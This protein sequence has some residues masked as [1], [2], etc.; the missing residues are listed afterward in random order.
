MELLEQ[1]ESYLARTRTP[2]SAFGR[3][4]LGDPRFVNDLRR[5]RK[6]RQQTHERVLRYLSFHQ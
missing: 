5:G 2:Q 4:V 3:T 6:P 1:V